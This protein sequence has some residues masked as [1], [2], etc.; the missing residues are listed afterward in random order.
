[1]LALP[2]QNWV[3]VYALVLS[4]LVRTLGVAFATLDAN[5]IQPNGGRENFVICVSVHLEAN[6]S[7]AIGVD[8]VSQL[9][10]AHRF[11]KLHA[12]ES[13]FGYAEAIIN[14]T[15]ECVLLE[16]RRSASFDAYIQTRTDVV[17]TQ[18]LDLWNLTLQMRQANQ[19]VL[20]PCC[21]DERCRRVVDD[22]AFTLDGAHA[23]YVSRATNGQ[24]NCFVW[25]E[26][27]AA[28]GIRLAAHAVKISSVNHAI[29]GLPFVSRLVETGVYETNKH[30]SRC[31][32]ASDLNIEPG[33]I[34]FDPRLV[35]RTLALHDIAVSNADQAPRRRRSRGKREK[36]CPELGS[37]VIAGKV[38]DD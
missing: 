19:S 2:G 32:K 18:P 29:L 37:R 20:I 9:D 30:H 16:S 27:V 26:G 7:G 5:I 35:N 17:V 10:R 36:R 34:N 14:S 33:S 12:Y 13:L 24:K 15:S 8:V 25:N 22:F 4:G 28:M 1:M 38:Y 23:D 21:I 6:E 3:M 11:D 31:S